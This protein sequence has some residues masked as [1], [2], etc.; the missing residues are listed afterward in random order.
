MSRVAVFQRAE[1]VGE[2]LHGVV[3]ICQGLKRTV[4]NTKLEEVVNDP[5]SSINR[6]VQETRKALEQPDGKVLLKDASLHN[7]KVTDAE[8]WTTTLRER[9]NALHWGKAK[10]STAN[11]SETGTLLMGA[12]M[13]LGALEAIQAAC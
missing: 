13:H 12:P 7:S 4:G 10:S 6:I 2:H 11:H 1:G 5:F 3:N 9:R 8:I